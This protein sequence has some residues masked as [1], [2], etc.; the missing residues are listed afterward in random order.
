PEE[1]ARRYRDLLDVV[2]ELQV[3]SGFC[4]TQFAD[5]Y[6]EANGLLFADRTPKIPIE[7]IAAATAGRHVLRADGLEQLTPL[8]ER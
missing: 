2:R 3:F 1:F 6:Q 7:E 8:E 5:T 4:Y